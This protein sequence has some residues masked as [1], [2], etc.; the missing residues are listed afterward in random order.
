MRQVA[1]VQH[2]AQQDLDVDLV[3]GAV[4]AGRVVDEVGVDPA[5]LERELDP[6]L[7]GAAEIAALAHHPAAQ[8]RAI[9]PD[10]V[11]EP[12]LRLGVGLAARL[13]VGADAAVPEQVDRRLED[14]VSS[15]RSGVR[16]SASMPS[17]AP[18]LGAERDR[19]GACAARRRRPG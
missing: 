9:D 6:A 4:D 8:V 11:V 16:L 1:G 15:A 12:V 17:T 19:L 7:L 18:G 2:R 13:D 5:A 10:R 3:V 14:R